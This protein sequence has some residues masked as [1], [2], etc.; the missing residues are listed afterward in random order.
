MQFSKDALRLIYIRIFKYEI[1]KFYNP[2]SEDIAYA[3]WLI[4]LRNV[5]ISIF[6]SEECQYP[7]LENIA[8]NF[9]YS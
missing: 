1:F 5:Q 6:L 3:L 7:I 2:I 4:L 8:I 9:L